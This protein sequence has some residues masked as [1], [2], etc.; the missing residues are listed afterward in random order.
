MNSAQLVSF[1]QRAGY[2]HMRPLSY[3]PPG[4]DPTKLYGWVHPALLALTDDQRK[5]FLSGFPS[6]F[7]SGEAPATWLML[8][9]THLTLALEVLLTAP[10]LTKLDFSGQND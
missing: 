8:Q 2:T 6:L 1:L 7:Q 3:R 5:A 9:P 10:D 4:G